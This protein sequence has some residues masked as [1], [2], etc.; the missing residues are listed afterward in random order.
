MREKTLLNGEFFE[1]LRSFCETYF[2]RSYK[3]SFLMSS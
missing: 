2:I 3:M 1:Y